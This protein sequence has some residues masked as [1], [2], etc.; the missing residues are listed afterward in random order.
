MSKEWQKNKEEIL[1]FLNEY[2]TVNNQKSMADEFFEFAH[3]TR[4][5]YKAFMK[6]GFT[7][8]E[9]LELVKSIIMAG[10]KNAKK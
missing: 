8:Q 6:E 2:I 1:E 4:E 9:S 10:M 5:T 7:A 3:V